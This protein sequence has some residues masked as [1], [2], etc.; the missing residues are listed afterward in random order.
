MKYSCVIFDW[1][2]TLADT[3]HDLAGA[4]NRVVKERGFEPASVGHFIKMQGRPI[5]DQILSV[6][7]PKEKD[8]DLVERLA[9]RVQ[10]LYREEPLNLG[11]PYKD[12]IELLFELKRKKIKCAIL[13]NKPEQI[14]NMEISRLFPTGIFDSINGVRPGFPYKPDPASVW[15]LLAELDASPRNAILAGDSETDM[16]TALAAECF[17]VGVSWGYR[18]IEVLKKAG[19]RRIINRPFEL[20]E[21]L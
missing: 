4:I 12:I 13:T 20:L 17:P 14:A 10:E 7:P 6:L 5:E 9:V 18:D 8:K 21:L 3:V 11:K 15:E 19:A 2:G 16:E 1:D